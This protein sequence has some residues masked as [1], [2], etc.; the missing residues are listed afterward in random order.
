MAAAGTQSLNMAQTAANAP[1]QTP[2]APVAGFSQDQQNAFQGVRDAQGMAQPYFDQAANYTNQSAG[3][4]TADQISQYF[5]PMASYVGAGLNNTF[6][7]QNRN[8]T[9]QA[10]Q[11]AG[12][13]GASRIGVAQG[14]L[15]RQ[16]GLAAGQTYAGLYQPALAAAQADKAR[17]ASAGYA[18]GQFGPAAQTAA[19][20]GNSAL[21]NTGGLQQQ[22][23][24][25]E[26]NSPYQQQLAQ[27]AY[28]FQTAQYPSGIT[29]QTAPA[30]GGTTNGESETTKPPPSI[31]SQIAGAGLAGLGIFS[32]NPGLVA[33]GLGSLGGGKGGGTGSGTTA[34]SPGQAGWSNYGTGGTN[35]PMF[36][37]GG[38]ALTDAP[39]KVVP[40]VE[41]SPG[42]S[43]ER[44][45]LH[46]LDP[47]Q[48]SAPANTGIGGSGMS[49]SELVSMGTKLGKAFKAEGGAV[50]PFD[51][52]KTFADGGTPNFGDPDLIFATRPDVSPLSYAPSNQPIAGNKPVTV[53]L[54]PATP[55]QRLNEGFADANQAAASGDFIQGGPTTYANTPF[56][57]PPSMTS[58][59][60]LPPVMTNTNA[61]TSPDDAV[62]YAS[63]TG[64]PMRVAQAN[65]GTATD[66]PDVSA[67]KT[68]YPE[69]DIGSD[70][71]KFSRSP[72]MA[73]TA[74]GLGIMGGESPYAGVNI[75]KGGLEG[76]KELDNQRKAIREEQSVNQAA[77]R[78]AQE[79]QQHL[80]QYTKMT[81][82]QKAQIKH[83]EDVLEQEQWAPLPNSLNGELYN[84]RDGTIK[85]NAPLV[86]EPPPPPP[87]QAAP[88]A[89]TTVAPN[90]G[91]I[92]SAPPEQMVQTGN[93]AQQAR[94]D[95]EL[96]AQYPTV[97]LRGRQISAANQE[98]IAFDKQVQ[99]ADMNKSRAIEMR[100]SL[101]TISNFIKDHP[102]DKTLAALVTPG[103]TGEVRQR[104]L[105][106]WA[107]VPGNK[108]PQEVVAAI[109]KLGKDSILGG[110]TNITA[111]GLSA[112]EAQP[113][114]RAGMSA[115][116][117][118]NIPEQSSRVLL[119]SMEATSDRVKDA[120]TFM[121]A[122]RKKNGGMSVGW[123]E[124]F[125]AQNPPEKYIARAVYSI[126]PQE[127]KQTLNGHVNELRTARDQLMQAEQ[128]G[129]RERSNAL[130][131]QYLVAK[132][133]F[134]KL[135]GNL[136]NYFAFGAF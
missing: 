29:G 95:P 10:T 55:V 12:G 25:A 75:G 80:D 99:A 115:I 32:G 51:F 34:M 54:N 79:A 76:I 105:N 119:A 114:I 110:M 42:R 53:P 102:N 36:A 6:A 63:R 33:G 56:D 117:S 44:P 62:E 77:K 108:A 136:G 38:A 58:Q 40:D 18:F 122:Y 49:A 120:K 23:Q 50:S 2:A 9:G 7:E 31:I 130:R 89:Q 35:Y 97:P 94:T 22:Q 52:G 5:N 45:W 14:E 88:L 20:Q 133:G 118:F 134:D 83:Q 131:Q 103:V 123:R 69:P 1:F 98:S 125:D 61:P 72:W 91:R 60:G 93:V 87:Q 47:T 100:G 17:Q 78:L 126:L 74:A 132:R 15:A 27:I 57:T 64:N 106:A 3:P 66:A 90:G 24:Q 124:A 104:I 81:P 86:P 43:G 46:G 11:A 109:N 121:D 16:Q 135:Y 111:T 92:V 127:A 4:V 116:A 70:S 96:L 73:L 71:D 28:P 128:S 19:L 13:V 39:D 41:A 101:D 37:S 30:L 129:D 85:R 113:I 112:R 59:K 68:P 26:L 67:G 48:V 84:K 107:S 21:L 65:T 8:T 82:Y